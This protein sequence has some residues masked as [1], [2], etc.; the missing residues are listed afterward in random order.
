MCS[1]VLVV[2]CC[3]LLC[4][5]GVVVG[6]HTENLTGHVSPPADGRSPGGSSY[7]FVVGFWPYWW[8]S[9]GRNQN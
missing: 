5:V 1:V 8:T 2:F 6:P 3:V 7:G 9:D 4:F